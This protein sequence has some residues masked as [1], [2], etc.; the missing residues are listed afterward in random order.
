MET[1]QQTRAQFLADTEA[2][3]KSFAY[4]LDGSEPVDLSAVINGVRDVVA[5]SGWLAQRAGEALA[6][7]GPLR[8]DTGTDPTTAIA[9]LQGHLAQALATLAVAD[10]QFT[11]AHNI[12]KVSA[13]RDQPNG[14]GSICR[15]F[16]AVDYAVRAGGFH[17]RGTR[18]N[19][20]GVE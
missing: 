9:E 8:H 18:A 2:R 3:I 17:R 1:D 10:D 19:R 13:E 7:A 16:A 11:A 6:K 15:K 14:P 5:I 4:E 20:S 12:S